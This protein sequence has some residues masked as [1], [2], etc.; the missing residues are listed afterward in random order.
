MFG[1]T[2]E[3][4]FP[5]IELLLQQAEPLLGVFHFARNVLRMVVSKLSSRDIF[6]FTLWKGLFNSCQAELVVVGLKYAQLVGRFGML[7]KSD[8]DGIKN[9]IVRLVY[10]INGATRSQFP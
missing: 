9:R 2:S 3:L 6:Q 7:T 4:R 5:F 1:A 8:I 10:L